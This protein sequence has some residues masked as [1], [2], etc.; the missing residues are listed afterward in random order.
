M[1]TAQIAATEVPIQGSAGRSAGRVRCLV[2][3]DVG[4]RAGGPG[5]AVGGIPAARRGPAGWLAPVPWVGSC[6]ARSSPASGRIWR[7]GLPASVQ[8]GGALLGHAAALGDQHSVGSRCR[9][10]LALYFPLFIGLSRVAVHRLRISPIVA[11]PVVW[12]GLEFA[13]AH[14]LT[15]FDMVAL[16]H[17]QY[18]WP[19]GVADQRPVRR[20]RRELL[21]HAGRGVRRPHAAAA[22]AR[23]ACW[24]P[25]R[26][27]GRGVGRGARSTASGGW[28]SRRPSPGPKVALIQGSIDIDMK[29]DP[30]EAEQIFDAVLRP[31]RSRP[32]ASTTIWI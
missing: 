4:H 17:T 5:A 19:A 30:D 1:G 18:R 26:A 6:G 27:A 21:D 28:T 2:A 22:M 32:S 14:L 20:L 16:A 25:A 29:H 8:P 24:W 10:Y 31:D 3:F 9:F 13:R 7:C 15:G 12:T 23:R 11:A